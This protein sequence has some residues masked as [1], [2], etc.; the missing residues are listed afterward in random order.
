MRKQTGSAGLNAAAS[1]V[2]RMFCILAAFSDQEA[3][4]IIPQ[5]PAQKDGAEARLSE[6]VK[7]QACEK[8]P[9][10]AQ[11]SELFRTDIIQE[12]YRRKKKYEESE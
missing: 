2:L 10:I 11:T 3:E 4:Q 9:G 12:Q 1:M 5:D 8:K 7:D 6:A